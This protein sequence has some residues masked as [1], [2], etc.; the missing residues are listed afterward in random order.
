MMLIVTLLTL[1]NME[2]G[3]QNEAPLPAI[4]PVADSMAG[5]VGELD[6]T[7]AGNENQAPSESGAPVAESAAEK[8]AEL[9]GVE[10]SAAEGDEV[11]EEVA[12][13]GK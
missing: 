11:R 4:A 9:D 7:E 2:A 13:E 3:G 1:A 6:E 10:A 12:N 8:V 5:R